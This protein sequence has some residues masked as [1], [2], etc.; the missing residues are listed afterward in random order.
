MNC[1]FCGSNRTKVMTSASGDDRV[2]RRRM[3][4]NCRERFTTVE[5]PAQ[6]TFH[7]TEEE[8][9]ALDEAQNAL[10]AAESMINR[11]MRRWNL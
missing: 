1:P 11:F 10:I 3:C 4:L 7:L 5:F 8:L 6:G 2:T 9:D